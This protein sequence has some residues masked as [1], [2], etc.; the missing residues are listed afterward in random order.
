MGRLSWGRRPLVFFL[1]AALAA[2]AAPSETTERTRSSGGDASASAHER[3]VAV[4][5]DPRRDEDRARDEYRHPLETLEF[6]GI[7]PDMTVADVFPSGGWYTRILAPYTAGDGGYIGLQYSEA[8]LMGVYGRRFEGPMRAEFEAF[9]QDYPDAVRADAPDV[10]NVAGY[11]LGSVPPEAAGAADAVLFIRAVH[12][13]VRTDAVDQAMADTWT[14]LKPGG[15]VG[16]VQHRAKPDAPDAYVD[17]EKGYLREADVIALF[18]AAG[19]V[20]EESSE[21]NA[22]PRDRANYPNG[23][24]TLPP[25]LTLGLLDRDDYLAIGESDRMTLR[26]RKPGNAG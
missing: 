15:V 10:T 9:T 11:I 14:L 25:S 26:F 24:W 7:A 23:V 1:V 16:V 13:L 5:D 21:I 18:E 3:L 20:F 22:N 6:F 2:C 4:L 17:G 12:N 8:T 19:F